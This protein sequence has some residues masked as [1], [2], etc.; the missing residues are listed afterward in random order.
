M[1][2]KALDKFV[3]IV[4]KNKFLFTPDGEFEDGRM[5]KAL[6]HSA[7][8]V[9]SRDERQRARFFPIPITKLMTG[10]FNLDHWFSRNN[11]YNFSLN[12]LI[13]FSDVGISFHYIKPYEMYLFEYLVYHVH[14]F[15]LIKNGSETLPKKLKLKEIIAASD[16]KSSAPNFR[17]H[18]DFHSLTSSEI[19]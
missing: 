13:G 14:P 2:K 6:K 7:I 9:D 19:F 4:K 18:K 8:F 12:G 11:Y 16:A 3:G 10:P 5:G 15:G 1:S 17:K